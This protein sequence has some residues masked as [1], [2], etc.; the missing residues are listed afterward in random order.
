MAAPLVLDFDHSVGALPGATVVDF[1]DRQEAIR[2]GCSL[3]TLRAFAAELDARLPREHGTVFLGSGDYH[4]LSWPLIERCAARAP[5]DVVVFDNHPDNMRFPFG[6]HCG[7]WVRKVA[8][9]PYVGHVHVLGIGSADVS[10]AHAWEN[11]L[12]PLHRRKLTYWTIGV[13]TRWAA[14]WGLA[15]AFRAFDSRASLLDRFVEEQRGA[16]RAVYLSIDKDVLDPA[17]ARTNWDQGCLLDTDL[18]SAIDALR[19]RLVASDVTGE[20][21][22]Y[23]Y[24]TWWK[25]R[26][27]A[28]DEQPTIDPV[29]LAAW[30][31][32]QHALNLRLLARVDAAR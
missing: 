10:R 22:A 15:T 2:F 3:R 1:A 12:A 4:H 27:S 7:S 23:R 32:Q 25:R 6:V 11:Y 29:Q 31:A 13:D 21:S 28:L 16:T 19:G 26:L 9:L 17:I 18:F 8:L 20:V 30:Q 14:R 5:F 24:S